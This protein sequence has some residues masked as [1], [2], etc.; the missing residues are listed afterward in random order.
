MVFHDVNI[1]TMKKLLITIVVIGAIIVGYWL[2]SPLF[3]NVRVSEEM[4]A[5]VPPAPLPQVLSE[6]VASG[7]FIGVAGHSAE[8]TAKL[9]KVGEKYFVRFDEDF[10]ITNGPDLFVYFGRDGVYDPGTQLAALKGNIG[11]QN[12]EVL[13]SIDPTKYNEIWVWCRAFRVGFGK[14]EIR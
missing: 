2:I 8:G 10:K 5:I 4:E 3:V 12:Y 6:T 9:I 7:Q 13:A 14:A 11:S 1:I